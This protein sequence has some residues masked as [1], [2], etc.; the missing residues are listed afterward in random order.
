MRLLFFSLLLAVL[1]LAGVAYVATSGGLFTVDGLFMILMLLSISAVFGIN[2]LLEARQAG[3]VP[4]LKAPA[5]AEAKATSTGAVA[6]Q[7]GVQSETGLIRDLQF[8]ESHVGEQNKTVVEFV[9]DGSEHAKYISFLGNVRDQLAPGTRARLSYRIGPEGAVL[10]A[11][12]PL[13]LFHR[14]RKIRS[15]SE[16]RAVS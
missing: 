9:P 16:A 8:F 4:F 11:R 13:R 5:S 2:A 14:S 6:A 10:V 7:S 12:E 3:L 1:P 15:G